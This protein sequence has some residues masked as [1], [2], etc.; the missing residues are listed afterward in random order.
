MIHEFKFSHSTFVHLKYSV[1]D[2]NQISKAELRLTDIAE[3]L[4]E[5]WIT[6]ARQLHIKE[7]E[8]TKI[9]TEYNYVTEQVTPIQYFGVF[10]VFKPGSYTVGPDFYCSFLMKPHLPRL[11]THLLTLIIIIILFAM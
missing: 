9:E 1:P 10:I 7:D 11:H 2:E 4:E 8:I 3:C 6:L 5:D